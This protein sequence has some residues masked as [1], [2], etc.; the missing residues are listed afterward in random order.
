MT[1]TPDDGLVVKE[2]SDGSFITKKTYRNGILVSEETRHRCGNITMI[3]YYDDD[4]KTHKLE[5]TYWASTDGKSRSV[6]YSKGKLEKMITYYLSGNK[7]IERNFKD[8]VR[9]G[10]ESEWYEDGKLCHE[11]SYSNGDFQKVLQLFDAKGRNCVLPDGKIIVWKL[12]MDDF[13]IRR[14]QILKYQITGNYVYVKLEVPADARRVT[15][16]DD[17]TFKSRVERATVLEIVDEKGN[18]HSSAISCINDLKIT[19]VVGNVAVPD[20]FDAD[21]VNKCSHGISVHL[22]KDHCDHW[23]SM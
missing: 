18:H 5:E 7:H 19:Y 1:T 14:N 8:D 9:H 22:H 2:H 6:F 17:T 13:Y 3:V 4:G 11:V 10:S 12:A 15:V 21:P 16:F 20:K 23:K